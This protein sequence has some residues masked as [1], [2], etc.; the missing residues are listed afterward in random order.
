MSRS[1]QIPDPV[2]ERAFAA[3]LPDS[4]RFGGSLSD[5]AKTFVEDVREELERDTW[6]GEG[7]IVNVGSSKETVIS[8]LVQVIF[9]V[10]GHHPEVDAKPAPPGS[11]ARRAPDVSKLTALGFTPEIELADGIRGCWEALAKGSPA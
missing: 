10:T 8:D 9:D 1:A 5:V 11:V 4:E 3:R 6:A 2:P 7:G